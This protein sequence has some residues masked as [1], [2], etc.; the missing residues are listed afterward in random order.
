MQK[1][2][3]VAKSLPLF[4]GHSVKCLFLKLLYQAVENLKYALKMDMPCLFYG[5]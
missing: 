1:I 4:L 3:T 5:N 2:G